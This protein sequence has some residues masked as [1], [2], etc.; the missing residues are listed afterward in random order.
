MIVPINKI[1]PNPKNPRTIRDEKFEKLK[2]SIRE[3]PDMLNK[4]PLICYT[5]DE[6]R[7]VVLGGNMRL[8]AAREI[9]LKELPITLADD[10]TEDQ[11]S[12]FLIKDNVSFGDWDYEALRVDFAPAVLQLWGMEIDEISPDLE[13]VKDDEFEM[14]EEIETDIKEGD[15][16]EIGQHRLLCGDSTK[17][18]QWE[19]LLITTGKKIDLVVTDPPYNVNYQGGTKDKM[20]IQGDNQTN[21]QFYNFLYDFYTALNEHV[22]QGGAWYVW[23]A[24]SEII[25]FAKAFVDAGILLKQQII[26]V[27]SS[28]VMGRQDYQ[29]KHEPC[30]YGWKPGAAH[31]FVEDRSQVTIYETEPLNTAKMSKDELRKELDKILGN[32]KYTSVINADKPSRNA[33]HP[34]MKPVL[35]IAQAIQNSSKAKQTVADGFLGSGTTMVAAHQ[36]NRTCYGM[37]LDPAYCQVIVNRM[38]ELDPTLPIYK[39]DKKWNV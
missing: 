20:T 13:Q 4:R 11:K 38:H 5:D 15:I 21:E 30:L 14:P 19:K 9:G 37:E 33:E 2:N 29:W 12:E 39:N 16:I 28:L 7:Y 6:G 23:H 34:T 32:Q 35:L 27:K 26:W 24:S 3:F 17:P 36:L 25:N 1:R 18:E 10:W 22:K 31:Y 8:K